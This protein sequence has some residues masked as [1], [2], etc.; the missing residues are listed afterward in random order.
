L[1][2]REEEILISLNFDWEVVLTFLKT[3]FSRLSD[4]NSEIYRSRIV[5]A[6]TVKNTLLPLAWR[7]NR[8]M[9]IFAGTKEIMKTIVAKMMGL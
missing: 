1:K 9:S 8:V 7:D 6:A 3:T 2:W 4:G 5:V